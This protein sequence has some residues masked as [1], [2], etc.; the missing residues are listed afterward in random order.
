MEK[1]EMENK[2][3][4]AKTEN[5]TNYQYG[6]RYQTF[7][8]FSMIEQLLSDKIKTVSQSDLSRN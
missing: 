5:S 1:I 2:K 6:G 7:E 4:R 8:E 3:D